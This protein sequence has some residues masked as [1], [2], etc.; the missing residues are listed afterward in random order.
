MFIVLFIP[1]VYKL[2]LDRQREVK[3]YHERQEREY[4]QQLMESN[5][6]DKLERPSRRKFSM[7]FLGK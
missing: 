6:D 4:Q 3:E 7:D 1:K 2:I 5:I